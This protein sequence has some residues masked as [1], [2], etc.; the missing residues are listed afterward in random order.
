MLFAITALFC[1]E[2][3]MGQGLQPRVSPEERHI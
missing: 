2:I 3:I 1:S